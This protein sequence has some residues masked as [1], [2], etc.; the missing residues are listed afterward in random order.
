MAR[1]NLRAWFGGHEPGPVFEDRLLGK[2]KKPVKRIK[3]K[4]PPPEEDENPHNV[5]KLAYADFMT[6]M[7]TFFLAMWLINA[8][9]KDKPL[10]MTSYFLPIKFGEPAPYSHGVRDVSRSGTGNA[11]ITD[12]IPN[13]PDQAGKPAKPSAEVTDEGLFH[14]PFPLLTDLARQAEVTVKAAGHPDGL[15]GDGKT[16]D[17]FLNDY[18]LT[19][20]RQWIASL[21]GS[22]PESGTADSLP[23]PPATEGTRNEKAPDAAGGPQEQMLA[24][25][26]TGPVSKEQQKLIENQ[27]TATQ[28]GRDL[29]TLAGTLPEAFRP[30]V[31]V[32]AN[33]DGILISLTDGAQFNMFKI[34]SA[35]PSPTLVLFLEKLGD[36]LNKYP[37]GI[38]VRGHTD[39][40][41]YAGDPYGNWRL[42]ANRATMTYYMLIRGKAADK[43][44]LALE[45]FGE[46]ELKNKAD[47]L[48]AENRRIEILIRPPGQS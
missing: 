48:A 33:A 20:V 4:Q 2:K 44:F 23:P 43:R 24:N 45:G 1:L 21:Q 38:I 32:S 42:S 15:L 13:D 17:T 30:N 39:A 16:H 28:L 3:W 37:G 34:A 35:V 18:I 6:A 36:L 12:I 46:R 22:G 40:R 7:M 10:G 31:E 14:N 9:L 47:P 11:K 41:P 5:W 26:K 8:A 27:K 25:P 29:S 19:P